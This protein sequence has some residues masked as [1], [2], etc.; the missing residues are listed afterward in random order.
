MS[1][2]KAGPSDHLNSPDHRTRVAAARRGRTQRRLF[3]SALSLIAEKG[4]AATTIDD[5]ISHANVAR[6]TFYNYFPSPECLVRELAIAIANE[7]IRMAE[8]VVQTFDDPAERV[9][10]GIRIVVRLAVTHRA[11]AAF[12]VR[13]GWP[14]TAGPD[15]LLQFVRRDLADG[16][17]AGRFADIPL[18]LA[19]NVVAG[20]V[21]GATHHMLQPGGDPAFPEWSAAASLRG[22][23]LDDATARRIAT[24]PLPPVDPLPD[25][26]LAATLGGDLGAVPRRACADPPFDQDPGDPS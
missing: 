5:V 24:L 20:T 10:A 15:L 7:L 16:V 3:A 8:P 14:D 4:L 25:G 6:G 9:S 13:L 26:L 2:P 23:G 1:A 21:V 17:G 19:L 22:L 11:V 18:T 12:L